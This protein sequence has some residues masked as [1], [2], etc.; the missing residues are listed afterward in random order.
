MQHHGNNHLYVNARKANEKRQLWLYDE[1]SKTIKSF[2]EYDRKQDK[3]SMDFRST[4][5]TV[6]NTD[7]RWHQMI[8]YL[9]SGHLMVDTANGNNNK[10][11][12]VVYG[13]HDSE[14]R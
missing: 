12:A 10:W 3:R 14:G 5:I 13:N 6:Q 11:Y 4:H 7:S 8:E 9:P 1:V 2:Y